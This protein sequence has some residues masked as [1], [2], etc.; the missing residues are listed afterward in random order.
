[1]LRYD[2]YKLLGIAR[3]ATLV[4]IKRAYR[5]RVKSCHPDV[6]PSPRAARAFRAVHEAYNVLSDIRR[7]RIYDEELRYYRQATP[8]S[9]ET[10]DVRKYG[11]RR[12]S[13]NAR[14]ETGDAMPA[15]PLDRFAFVGLH[16][17]GL[18]FGLTLV[19]GILAGVTFH[20]WP[21]AMLLFSTFGLAVL[22]DSL[23][24]LRAGISH[25]AA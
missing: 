2:H 13:T 5:A 6:N 4:Q 12:A 15:G 8:P 18:L 23:H 3:D 10:V 19:L 25:H 22:P 20:D 24:G 11:H 9:E 17:T 16:L 7:R 14:T 21:L 1:M